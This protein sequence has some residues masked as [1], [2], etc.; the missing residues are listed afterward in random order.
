MI[1][2]LQ[3]LSIAAGNPGIAQE[4]SECALSL[5]YAPGEVI[6]REGDLGRD[7]YILVKGAVSVQI[8]NVHTLV[9]SSITHLGEFAMM[10]E[11]APRC[12]TLRAI[13]N[14][15]CAKINER[16]FIAIADKYPHI[17]TVLATEAISRV[18]ET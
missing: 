5:K 9:R 12:A 2:Q 10:D 6:V 14:V 16:E 15:V 4:L 11:S 8:G 7:L 18:C 17:W 1:E 13:D 3:K